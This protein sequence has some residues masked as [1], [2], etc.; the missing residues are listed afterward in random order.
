MTVLLRASVLYSYPFFMSQPLW[1][2]LY[3]IILNC[4]LLIPAD[5]RGGGV[6][7]GVG[8]SIFHEDRVCLFSVTL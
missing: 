8:S 7:K 6:G 3:N 4:I 5:F 1:V 2:L